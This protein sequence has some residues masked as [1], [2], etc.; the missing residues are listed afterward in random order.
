MSERTSR[1]ETT[2]T[3]ADDEWRRLHRLQSAPSRRRAEK[4][5]S[6]VETVPPRGHHHLKF[7]AMR[8]GAGEKMSSPVAARCAGAKRREPAQ[9]SAVA[10]VTFWNSKPCRRAVGSK[11]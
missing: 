9:H 6:K 2:N 8:I 1:Y 4:H 3:G 10:S 5:W 7:R 11:R